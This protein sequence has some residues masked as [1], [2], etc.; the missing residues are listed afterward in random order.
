METHCCLS[1]QRLRYKSKT[2][3]DLKNDKAKNPK[4]VLKKP[5]QT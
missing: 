4:D 2:K 3:N 1:L 5:Q